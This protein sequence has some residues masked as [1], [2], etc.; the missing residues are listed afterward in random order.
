MVFATIMA[1]QLP[2]ASHTLLDGFELLGLG[3]R[4]LVHNLLG[5][6]LD[7]VFCPFE[8]EVEVDRCLVPLLPVDSH[9]P[10][11]VISL[12]ATNCL[13]FI[14]YY[15]KKYQLTIRCLNG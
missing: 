13:L 10:P 9:H 7:L 4:N 5:R 3:Q 12:P 2:P 15:C 1:Q 11:L 14:V 8:C 6:T